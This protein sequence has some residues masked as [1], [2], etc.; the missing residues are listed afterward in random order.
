MR[1][2]SLVVSQCLVSSSHV[3]INKPFQKAWFK[4]NSKSGS[5]PAFLLGQF[6][7]YFWQNF[8]SFSTYQIPVSPVSN[9]GLLKSV[10]LHYNVGNQFGKE[11]IANVSF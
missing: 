6:L 9:P 4:F 3:S 7:L 11:D 8:P 5:R 1:T 10:G 2:S